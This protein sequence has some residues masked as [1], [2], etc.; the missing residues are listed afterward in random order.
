M[1]F[2]CY[3][4]VHRISFSQGRAARYAYGSVSDTAGYSLNTKKT[5]NLPKS[6]FVLT[7]YE[8]LWREALSK[9]A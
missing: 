1:L 8:T 5:T 2:K 3:F 4:D 6:Q 9:I 7:M